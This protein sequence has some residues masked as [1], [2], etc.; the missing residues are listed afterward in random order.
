[1]GWRLTFLFCVCSPYLF[2]IFL[3]PI[4]R[5][6]LFTG[7]ETKYW[8]SVH[9]LGGVTSGLENNSFL[10]IYPRIYFTILFILRFLNALKTLWITEATFQDFILHFRI[11]FYFYF[12]VYWLMY[13][14]PFEVAFSLKSYHPGSSVWF[15]IGNI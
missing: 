6:K 2:I 1:M 12:A 5:L 14:F 4:N 13:G 8:N 11:Y 10:L 15:T 7:I 9:K 3:L